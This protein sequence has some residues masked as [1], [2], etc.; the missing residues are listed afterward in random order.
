MELEQ[1]CL[2]EEEN[3]FIND[4]E[5]EENINIQ[6]ERTTSSYRVTTVSK[7]V[8]VCISS[9]NRPEIRKVTSDKIRNTIATVSYR[10]GISVPKARIA[11]QA[12]CEIL[13]GHKYYL[14]VVAQ[15]CLSKIQ[16]NEE[17]EE[18]KN[19]KPRTKEDYMQYKDVLPDVKAVNDYK[20]CRCFSQ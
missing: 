15:P 10:S 16:E 11:V 19:K 20:H 9:I 12:V 8:Q 4:P 13:Y 1:S 6:R 3:S 7:E 5:F 18:P 2:E 14:C 17:P